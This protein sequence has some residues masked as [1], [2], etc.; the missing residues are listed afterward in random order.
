MARNRLEVRPRSSRRPRCRECRR[1]EPAFSRRPHGRRPAEYAPGSHGGQSARRHRESLS[2]LHQARSTAPSSACVMRFRSVD[3]H[4]VGPRRGMEPVVLPA[5]QAVA[6]TAGAPLPR[7]LAFMTH[8]HAG[9][10]M[11]EWLAGG[12]EHFLAGMP[13]SE[14]AGASAGLT[15][16]QPGELSPGC[17]NR[18][19]LGQ[20]TSGRLSAFRYPRA[21][22][23]D[24]SARGRSR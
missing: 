15:R 10:R 1:R 24:A 11:A 21:S 19:R 12:H 20:T 22:A 4:S 5:D 17:S 9:A 6:P 18:L 2:P 13:D 7:R 23:V 3:I 14:S 16:M 8:K